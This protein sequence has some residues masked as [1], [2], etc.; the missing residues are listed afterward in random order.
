M[1]LYL[2]W[3]LQGDY[4]GGCCNCPQSAEHCSCWQLGWCDSRATTRDP[5]QEMR[6]NFLVIIKLSPKKGFLLASPCRIGRAKG[7]SNSYIEGHRARYRLC[8]MIWRLTKQQNLETLVSF[9]IPFEASASRHA[10]GCCL[11]LQ[12]WF[13]QLAWSLDCKTSAMVLFLVPLQFY[14]GCQ[15][16]SD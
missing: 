16:L 8:V 15:M 1:S 2:R 11:W 12:Y 3:R 9:G 6:A 4:S 13:Q 10:C 14:D 7:R 5:W